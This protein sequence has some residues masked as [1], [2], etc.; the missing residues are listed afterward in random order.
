VKRLY[1]VSV[2]ADEP[3]TIGQRKAYNDALL[4]FVESNLTPEDRGKNDEFIDADAQI[5]AWDNTYLG[6]GQNAH[7]EADGPVFE[8]LDRAQKFADLIH[9]HCSGL[10]M[11]VRVF[12]LE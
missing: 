10:R 1:E 3:W 11:S 6:M 8:S 2:E 7:P 9:Y 4:D 12:V 5:A